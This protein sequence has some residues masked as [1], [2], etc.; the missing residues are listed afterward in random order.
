MT[1]EFYLLDANR[2]LIIS[3]TYLVMK[4]FPHNSAAFLVFSPLLSDLTRTLNFSSHVHISILSLMDFSNKLD[5]M[6]LTY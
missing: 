5:K 6:V 4:F 3:S 1:L 2:E